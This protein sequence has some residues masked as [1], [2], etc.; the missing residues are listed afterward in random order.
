MD[1]RSADHRSSTKPRELLWIIDRTFQGWVCSQCEWNYPLPT[2]LTD[3]EAK[4]AYDRLATA[5]FREHNCSDHLA[6]LA[7]VADTFT[8]RIRKMVSH[9]YK[10]KDAV[11]LVLQEV[12]LEYR[13]QPKVLAQ[14]QSE[15]DDFL[16]RLRAG[17][18]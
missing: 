16:R 13:N 5:K 2:L 1:Q 4:T 8:T 14:A 9:G 17:L 10:P 18:I 15:A 12:Q 6:R 3:P 11:E 7:S